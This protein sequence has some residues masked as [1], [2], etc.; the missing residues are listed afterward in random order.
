MHTQVETSEV[1]KKLELLNN[2]FLKRKEDTVVNEKSFENYDGVNMAIENNTGDIIRVRQLK[3]LGRDGSGTYLYFGYIYNAYNEKSK[4]IV[5]LDKY[6]MPVCF[7][8]YKKLEDI[9][10]DNN[11][12]EIIALLHLL[13]EPKNFEKY[14]TVRYIGHLYEKEIP[15]EEGKKV[16]KLKISRHLVSD[17]PAIQKQIELLQR[18]YNPHKGKVVE[19]EPR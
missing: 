13:S 11:K 4:E 1:Q 14:H 9:A 10:N 18:D 6:A 17:S 19:T 5:D 12:N 16:K 8:T 3:K 15:N 7:E 2:P